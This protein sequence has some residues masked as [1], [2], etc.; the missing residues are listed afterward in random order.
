[1][2]F[3]GYF[4]GVVPGASRSG[5]GAGGRVVD[6]AHPPVGHRSRQ[7]LPERVDPHQGRADRRCSSPR[8]LAFGVRRSPYRSRRPRGDLGLIAS[9]AVRRRP[10]VRH[11]LLCRLECRD[12]HRRR[13][14]RS[15]AHRCRSRCVAAVGDRDAPLRRPQ[16]R[17]PLHHPRRPARR[18]RSMWPSS[19]ASTSSATPAG[20]S[21]MRRHLH[22][23]HFLHQRHDVDRAR[24]SPW[25]WARTSDCCPP[26]RA[27]PSSGVPALA[28][29]FQLAVVT[30]LLLSR[31]ASS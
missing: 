25:S 18:A 6:L 30:V 4:A 28:I 26:S 19:P 10:R 20:A 29:L 13:G 31:K 3:G 14:A 23:P 16:R 15:Q 7:H 27:R 17:I 12:L 1:M 21:S 8:P 22:R 24:A 11:V 5:P 9:P 2:A